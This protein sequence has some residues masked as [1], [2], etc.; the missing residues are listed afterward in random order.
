M[1]GLAAV[2]LTAVAVPA[3]AAVQQ[4]AK[5]AVSGRAAQ[6]PPPV[7]PVTPPGEHPKTVITFAWGGG[8]ASQMQTLSVFRHYHMHAT[9]FVP[10]G[11]VC[12]KSNAQCG[13]SP[14][15]TLG[16]IRTIA[17]YGNEIGGLSVLHQNLTTIPVAEAKREVC[18]DR[19]NLF[20]WGFQPTDF[21]YPFAAENATIERITRQCGY[22]AGLGAGELRGGGQC[23]LCAYAETLPP[24]TPMLVRAPDE[25]N[26]F[27]HHY[28]TLSTYKSIVRGAQGHDGGWIFLTIHSICKQACA[29]G[30]TLG[31]LR[32]V[33]SWLQSQKKYNVQVKTMRQV[34]G[35]PVRPAV[36]GPAPRRLPYPGV[37]NSKLVKT[38]T[39]KQ[40]PL[41]VC[42]QRASYG[43]NSTSFSYSP[44][45][46]PNGDPTETVRVTKWA[47]GG[48]KLLPVM[49]LGAC[50]PTV[51]GGR[52]YTVG[53]WYKSSNPTQIEIYC[54]N[55][56]GDWFYW[57]TSPG[58]AAT[59][60][61]KQ[62]SFTTPFV[63][64]GITAMS[65]GLTA[66][67]NITI[68]STAY[69]IGPAKSRRALVLLGFFV[70]A[71]VAGAL[72]TRGQLRYRK[73]IRAEELAAAQEH[74]GLGA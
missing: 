67:G 34:I 66:N 70:F 24:Q 72:I 53:V 73:H 19:M 69:S 45:G 35:G 46:G 61:W 51:T 17:S 31:Q 20:H 47:S 27:K 3:S 4:G 74:A 32:Q 10:T 39:T 54:R 25:V 21:A 40:G 14:Y 5:P 18:D 55:Q 60:S 22:N 26:A 63:P 36:A 7:I 41:P 11:L 28:W 8:W 59:D 57:T 23:N 42:F 44:A 49:D 13:H 58:F 1:A 64:A 43:R 16:D 52:Q 38:T 62:A 37:A 68:T 15:L 48:A 71:V 30:I 56:L 65:F 9:Y 33:L 12:T 29:Y 6:A 50:S 2:M